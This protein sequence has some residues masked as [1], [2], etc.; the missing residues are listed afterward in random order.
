MNNF[1]P[2]PKWEKPVLFN[3]NVNKTQASCDPSKIATGTDG[4]FDTDGITPCNASS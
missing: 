2:Y 3:L 1:N 4:F